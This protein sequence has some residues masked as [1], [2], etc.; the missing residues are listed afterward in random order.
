MLCYVGFYFGEESW[1]DFWWDYLRKVISC[2]CVTYKMLFSKKF[3]LEDFK[4]KDSYIFLE[5]SGG[6]E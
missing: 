3:F 1:G 4:N 2:N 5:T 6:K